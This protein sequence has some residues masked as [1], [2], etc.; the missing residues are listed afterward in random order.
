MA[1]TL[2][3]LGLTNWTDTSDTWRDDDVEHLQA[4][5]V[6]RFAN[7]TDA[8]SATS[9]TAGAFATRGAVAYIRGAAEPDDALA[10]YKNGAWR[11][12]PAARYLRAGSTDSTS[13]VSISHSGAS[14]TGLTLNSDGTISATT[15]TITDLTSTTANIGTVALTDS[16]AG[17]LNVNGNL[18]ADTI[19]STGITVSGGGSVTTTGTISAGV[20]T[21]TG[22]SNLAAA[23]ASS[24]SVGGSTSVTTTY[25]HAPYLASS[26]SGLR[27]TGN[28]IQLGSDTDH[29]IDLSAWEL[30]DGAP[31]TATIAGV[32]EGSSFD[33]ADY[34]EGTIW[35]E[36][37]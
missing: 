24:L 33:A 37:P 25:V 8:N 20:L 16:P 18:D 11:Y 12:L 14:G 4:R 29:F 27:V 5:T 23:S 35:I 6:V 1:A 32:I 31:N 28:R 15:G 17:T 30:N 19:T 2:N 7:E 10:T 21:A 9:D 34:P 22:S 3:A 36:T 26:A 13:A